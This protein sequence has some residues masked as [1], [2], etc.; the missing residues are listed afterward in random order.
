MSSTGPEDNRLFD[1]S[2]ASDS[3]EEGEKEI[4]LPFRLLVLGEFLPSQSIDDYL[5]TTPLPVTL[6]NFDKLMSAQRIR[7]QI[8]VWELE[9][10]ATCRQWFPDENTHIVLT[11][12]GIDDF[13]PE[14]LSQREPTLSRVLDTLVRIQTLKLEHRSNALVDLSEVPVSDRTLLGL[15]AAETK[16]T[17]D[18]LDFLLTDVAASLNELLNQIIHH[19]A[20]QKLE[21]AWRGLHLLASTSEGSEECQ[22]VFF[23]V[24]KDNLREDLARASD[25]AETHLFDVLYAHEYGQFGGKPYGAVIADYAFEL[26]DDDLALLRRLAILGSTAHA[27]VISQAAPSFF[28]VKQFGDLT[29]LGSL[30][31]MQSG[32]RFIKWRALQSSPEAMYLVLTLPRILMR[33]PY[34][35]ENGN[36][37]ASIFEEEFSRSENPYLWANA[38]YAMATCL[39][40]SFQRYGICTDI[41]GEVGGEVVGLPSL[42]LKNTS[43]VLLPVEV[44]FSENKEAELIG[45]GFTPLS[46]AKAQEKILFY[47]AYSVYWGSLQGNQNQDAIEHLGAQLPYLFVIL[48]IAHYLKMICRDMIGAVAS[49]AELE[50]QL[51]RWLKRYVSDVESPSA[52]VR[53][54]RPLKKVNLKVGADPNRADWLRVELSVMPHLKYLDQDFTLRLDMNANGQRR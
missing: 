17:R 23:P 27:P 33:N 20:L 42:N 47:S 5:Q 13:N 52:S 22:V 54:R 18:V 26:N 12:G 38:S 31:G 51:Q 45:L 53:L 4:R 25:L 15:P 34:S 9:L 28:G 46:V 41:T 49:M 16:F 50:A 44:L 40:R 32:E 14:I 1:F 2:Y 3:S 11:L 35:I 29:N 10:G 36:V 21:G 8:P 43:D 48:R 39:L 7:L 37:N 30:K 6:R 24:S 19:P